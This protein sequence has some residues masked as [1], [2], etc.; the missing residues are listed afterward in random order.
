MGNEAISELIGI[1]LR[2]L[3][4]KN[5]EKILRFTDFKNC[6]NIEISYDYDQSY[7]F[8]EFYRHDVA[9]PPVLKAIKITIP[10]N[11][12]SLEVLDT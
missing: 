11:G 10:C 2:A 9:L 3:T 6:E 5:T 7:V 1:D 4:N 8:E 12:Y